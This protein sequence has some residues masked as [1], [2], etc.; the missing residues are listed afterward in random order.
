MNTD[1]ESS[2]EPHQSRTDT[3][4]RAHVAI[5]H[6]HLSADGGELIAFVAI[7]FVIFIFIF[8]QD[9]LTVSVAL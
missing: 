2:D 6:H 3:A 9:P 1:S 8:D 5:V 4:C 7:T